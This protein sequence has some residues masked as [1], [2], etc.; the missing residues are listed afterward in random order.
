MIKQNKKLTTIAAL[1]LC[2]GTAH[3]QT[4]DRYAGIEYTPTTYS[5][6]SLGPELEFDNA[7]IV[8]RAGSYIDE[9]IS[10]EA[11][12]GLGISDDTLSASGTDPDL[13]N[14]SASLGFEINTLLGAYLQANSELPGNL[15]VYGLLGFSRINATVTGTISSSVYGTANAS[16]DD[17]ETGLSYGGGV[18]VAIAP[19]TALSIEYMSYLDK[20]DF[21][22]TS[23]NLGI[24]YKY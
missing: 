3:A 18:N 17:T 8:G 21:D 23:F 5:D 4:G 1:A 10:L 6:R 20:S 7:L 2:C 16:A 12:F 22:V 9:N 11:R 19:N 15:S 13:G 14:Y 24:M